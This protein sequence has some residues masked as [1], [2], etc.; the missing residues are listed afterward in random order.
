MLSPALEDAA[1]AQ[2]IAP[3]VRAMADAG[4]PYSGVLFAG[5]MLTA[6]GPKLI[7]YNARFGDPECQVLMLRLE[8]DLVELLDACANG[9][10]AGCSPPSFSSDTAL[11]V[12]MAARGYPGPPKSG[13]VSVPPAS[14]S[15][16]RA[17]QPTGRSTRST[18]PSCSA[19]TT[20]AGAKWRAKP[21]PDNRH[22]DTE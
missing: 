21:Q 19:A 14:A 10:L 15:P 8:S 12:V 1:Y 9:R 17:L 22:D 4:T 3:T 13:S 16:R 11:A 18:H 20:S 2:I 5:L 7:E 6:D